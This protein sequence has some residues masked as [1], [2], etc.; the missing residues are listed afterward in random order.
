MKKKIFNGKT[1]RKWL[2]DLEREMKTWDPITLRWQATNHMKD[3][4]WDPYVYLNIESARRVLRNRE[5]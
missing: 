3:K 5:G 1:A 2:K 4:P